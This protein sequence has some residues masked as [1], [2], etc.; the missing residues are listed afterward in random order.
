MIPSFCIK[1]KFAVFSTIF[2]DFPPAVYYDFH[3]KQSGGR[4][5]LKRFF[6][7]ILACLLL[8]SAAAAETKVTMYA[9]DG[10]T[11]EVP[12]SQVEAHKKVNWF[13]SKEEVTTRMRAKDGRI[14]T[15]WKAE[16]PAYIK[17]NWIPMQD[18]TLDPQKPMVALTYDDGPNPY[19]TPKI[20]DTLE[21]YNAKATF[22][23]L[24]NLASRYPAIVQR[25]AS[26]GCLVGNHS[27]SHSNLPTLKEQ[28]M[29]PQ[30]TWTDNEIRKATGSIA[31]VM[32]PPYGNHNDKLREICQKP[33]ILWNMDTLDWKYRS[34]SR[35]ANTVLS[36]VKD[37]DIV[38]MHDI[39]ST[40]AKATETIVPELLKRGFQLVT[41]EELA[42]YRGVTLEKGKTYTDF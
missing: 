11:L 41:V 37:G 13:T 14:L 2:L 25:T 8:C 38:L 3:R 27:W 1:D 24:G 40:T 31:S 26:T 30:I 21:F 18:D 36:G 5:D 4:N 39:Y 35:V 20:L 42:K 28:D 16:V 29:L 7:L 23:V 34:S 9:K 19:S 10:R 32:R 6:A 22:F 33:L 17:V 15:V 12:L